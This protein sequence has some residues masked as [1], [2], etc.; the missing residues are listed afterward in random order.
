[1]GQLKGSATRAVGLTNRDFGYNYHTT[2][3]VIIPSASVLFTS[4]SYGLGPANT[5]AKVAIQIQEFSRVSNE[6]FNDNDSNDI[7][8]FN[9]IPFNGIVSFIGGLNHISS[10]T[11]NSVSQSYAVMYVSASVAN[12]GSVVGNNL[13]VNL[14][15]TRL[16]S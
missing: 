2:S 7:R 4:S 6:N 14:G 12:M 8:L 1:M 10:S 13:V 9:I 5:S 16:R 15:T 3:S 11:F